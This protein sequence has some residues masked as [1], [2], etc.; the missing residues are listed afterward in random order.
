MSH[1]KELPEPLN[2]NTHCDRLNGFEPFIHTGSVLIQRHLGNFLLFSPIYSEE[3][4][5][6]Y[7]QC[8]SMIILVITQINIT[9][10]IINMRVYY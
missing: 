6:V 3:Y 1:G 9:N 2:T 4:L 10:H 7:E 5:A 8:W